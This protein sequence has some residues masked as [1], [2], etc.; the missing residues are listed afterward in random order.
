MGSLLLF[1]LRSRWKAILGW[2]L[3]LVL[4][5]A[6]YI[7]VYP[8][9]ETE[10]AGLADL[11]VYSAM[12]IDL[13][14]FPAYVGSVVLLFL[15]LLLGIYSITSGTRTIAG[16]E[17][18]GTLELLMAHPIS[19]SQI[20]IAKA[21]ALGAALA[22]ILVV[23]G[24]G[25]ALVLA[26]VKQSYQTELL[27]GELFRALI[28][29]WPITF[30]TAMIALFLAALLPTRR[31][32]SLTAAVIF[33][34]GY[35]G[36]NIAGMVPTLEPVKPFT[37]FAYYDSSA[38]AIID[39]PDGRDMLILLAVALLAFL[40]TLVSFQRRNVTVGAWPFTRNRGP[41]AEH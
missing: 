5:G 32:A 9:V 25:N 35:F 20:V 30:A 36:E 12:G 19:R 2:G 3:G 4:F 34:A 27:P 28:A 7:S 23:A 26:I 31:M 39:G 17:E 11:A 38:R 13:A 1:E 29:A 37:L 33:V 14:S 16:E 15:P 22:A 40:L 18:E 6:V 10:M 24:S 41:S 8:Q 21:L